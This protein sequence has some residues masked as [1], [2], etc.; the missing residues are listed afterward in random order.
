MNKIAILLVLIL[1]CKK[2][3]IVES[4]F[5]SL[6]N[7]SDKTVIAEVNGLVVTLNPMPIGDNSPVPST[8][9]LFNDQD[10]K[11]D[12][13]DGFPKSLGIIC[14]C[15]LPEAYTFGDTVIISGKAYSSITQGNTDS[16]GTVSKPFN[17]CFPMTLTNIE[18]YNK[19]D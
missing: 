10:Q 7:L 2:Q 19:K 4:Q 5:E 14:P 1:G 8:V 12:V 17:Y 11:L 6:C 13:I 18:Y 15:N 16:L 3:E 9:L